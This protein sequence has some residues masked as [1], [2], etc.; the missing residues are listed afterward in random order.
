MQSIKFTL[1]A[2]GLLV[3]LLVTACSHHDGQGEQEK[4]LNNTETP[5][6]QTYVNAGQIVPVMQFTDIEG[7]HINLA[8]S[9]R[10]KLLIL[11]ATWCTDSQRAMK[12]LVESALID[13]E[14]I[15][16]IGIGREETPE[17]LR[18]FAKT[19]H[20]SFALVADTDRNIYKQFANAGIPR[21]ILLDEDNHIVK[22][23]LLEYETKE[24]ELLAPVQW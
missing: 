18:Q 10:K 11:F 7:L 19:H 12:A 24:G 9:N 1:L 2:G 22:T 14:T 4:V 16:I 6:Y 5:K 13:D 17:D 3:S 23:L 20:L 15:H 8:E 21:F